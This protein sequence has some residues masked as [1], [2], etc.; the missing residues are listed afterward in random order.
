MKNNTVA[1][2]D[3]SSHRIVED[4]VHYDPVQDLYHVVNKIN[5][6]RLVAILI[7]ETINAVTREFIGKEY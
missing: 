5:K 6:Y 7:K 4:P 1:V 3:S 2:Q